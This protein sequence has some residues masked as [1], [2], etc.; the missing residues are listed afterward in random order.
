MRFI[1]HSRLFLAAAVA[2]VAVLAL[3]DPLL[4]ADHGGAEGGKGKLPSFLDVRADLGIYTLVVFALLFFV[5][6]KY[7][8]PHIAEGLKKREA[9]IIGA[10]EEAQR[11]RQAAE[12]RLAEAKK[13]LDEAADRA[14]VIV[15][16]ARKA[17]E[18]MQAQARDA[19]EKAAADQKA[20]LERDIASAKDAAMQEI[21]QQAVELAS[22]LT[23][24][25][26]RRQISADDHRRL[27]DEALADLKTGAGRN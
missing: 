4:A 15:E 11:D 1:A 23:T 2:V 12:Q 14:R 21:Y 9:A 10:R 6:S 17:A 8:W 13:Q 5:L 25:T 22:M 7:A 24:K 26:L 20:Q 19:R 18:A 27:L 16:E 3:A